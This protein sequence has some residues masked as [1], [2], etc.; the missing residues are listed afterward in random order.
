MS[1]KHNQLA[2]T[3]T[4]EILS[5]RYQAGDRLPSE[6]E[7]AVRF[8]VNR[9][10]VREAMSRLSQLG[11]A[12]IQPGGAR[13]SPINE[14]SLDIIGH[15]LSTTRVPDA[16]L[17]GQIFEVVERLLSMA[18][19][20][21]VERGQ[22]EDVEAVRARVQLLFD[23][24]LDG[25]AHAA[26]R[27]EMMR[28]IMITSGNLVCQLIAHGLFKQFAPTLEAVKPYVQLDVEAFNPSGPAAGRGPGQ[29]RPAR[30]AGSV[31][32]LRR[33]AR[34]HLDA[35][36]RGR[37]P[38]IRNAGGGRRIMKR[39]FLFPG[40]VILAATFG[41]VALMATSPQLDPDIPEPVAPTVRV[42]DV[43]P[44]S[45]QLRVHSQGT[46]APNQVTALFPEVAGRG[47]L[48][49]PGPR[50]RRLLRE[51]RRA[52]E[53][54]RPG[55]PIGPAARPSGPH[56]GRSRVRPRPLRASA[57]AEPGAAPPGQPLADGKHL[58]GVAGQASGP[59]GRPRQ[60]RS[61]PARS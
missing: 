28:T 33:A 35:G 47:G 48:D 29:P 18:A 31:R 15:M 36:H 5:G 54:R 20:A 23:N 60:L 24:G 55:L 56:P 61:G 46:V 2:G 13:V 16:Q 40:L 25:E 7:L 59:G 38:A 39:K 12:D 27:I 19:E 9:G 58:E 37:R 14:A 32:R 4:D 49:F 44:E 22:A 41:A 53:T 6:R 3:L 8:N 45:I 21:L 43:L 17:L 34:P 1:A 57:H 10:A 51:G 26:A 30:R 42:R 52:A 11:V 50:Q